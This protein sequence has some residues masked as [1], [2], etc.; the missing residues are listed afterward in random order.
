LYWGDPQVEADFDPRGFVDMRNVKTK[1]EFLEKINAIESSEKKWR[2]IV[3][4][5]ALTAAK[6]DEVREHLKSVGRKILGCVGASTS[7]VGQPAV[8]QQAPQV[9]S[10]SESKVQA[11]VQ[12]QIQK[13]SAE[14][15]IIYATAFNWKFMSS[16]E[17]WTRSLKERGVTRAI[18]YC[19]SDIL[20]SSFE[21]LKNIYTWITFIRI[22]QLDIPGFLDWNA[23]QHY[24]W[25][26][27]CLQ[28]IT[29]NNDLSGKT[30]IYTDSGAFVCKEPKEWIEKT[31]RSGVCLLEDE[32]QINRHW[33]H[34]TFCSKLNVT[35]QEKSQQQLMAGLIA[36]V[37]GHLVA[38]TL[39]TEAW[40]WGQQRDVIVGPKWQGVGPDGKPYGHRHDQSILSILS[41]RMGV[42]RLPLRSVYC[43]R[44]LRDTYRTGK[45][46]YVHRGNFKTSEQFAPLISEAHV[47]NL[48]RRADRMERFQKN[49]EG[50]AQNVRKFNAY[51]G[52]SITL[53]PALARLF[54]PHD[55][56]WKKAILG[57]ALSHL[58]LWLSLI[59]DTADIG[60][61]LIMEDDVKFKEGWQQRWNEAAAHA[62]DDWDVIYLGGILPPNRDGFERVKE[63]VNPYFSRVALNQVFGQQVPSRYFHFCNYSYI[64]SRKGAQKIIDTLKSKDGYWTS[65][66]HMICN[67]HEKMN[68]Y[69][70]DPL[71]AGCYQDD[72]PKYCASAF[73]NYSRVDSFDS[74]LW[75][76][77]ERF[78]QDEIMRCIQASQSAPIAFGTALE[79]ARRV[80]PTKKQEV[81]K[82]EAKSEAKEERFYIFNNY[83]GVDATYYEREWIKE[84]FGSDTYIQFKNWDAEKEGLP[85]NPYVLIYR[86]PDTVTTYTQAKKLNDE[87]KPFILLHLSDEHCSD[88]IDIYSLPMCKA[89]L[90]NYVRNDI[91]SSIQNKVKTIPLGPHFKLNGQITPATKKYVW[92]FHGTEWHGRSNTIAMLNQLQPNSFELYKTWQDANQLK[93]DE[94]CS[95]MREAIFVPCLRGNNVETYRFYEALELGAI[96]LIVEEQIGHPYY[97]MLRKHMPSLVI[98]G[99]WFD[100]FQFVKEMFSNP[101][102]IEQYHREIYTEWMAWKDEIKNFIKNL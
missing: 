13:E 31:R 29:L 54:R 75:N 12:S 37:A 2:E 3:R 36:F 27:W 45:S 48:E 40:K 74:D 28:D 6:A 91:P 43:D 49:H 46:I 99:S 62:P 69:F 18:A 53:T 93:Q 20:P 22:P 26:L 65:A 84:I 5:P 67:N 21:N 39:F 9:V 87:S 25:K 51:D 11:Q 80:D 15:G 101:T 63:K 77:D 95:K 19:M 1:E 57:C 35:E 90:R 47:I 58:E 7:A 83:G 44:S 17:L 4:T 72:D 64:L 8:V 41:A 32:E 70:L 68:L 59:T 79:D 86:K 38:N 23:P 96:P 66:D 61:Y 14:S 34:T 88:P 24:A 97:A 85:T 10:V 50:W 98:L 89:V 33:C 60:S 30:I 94:Y 82:K 73:N 71:V 55:F 52:R 102:K 100:S 56:G 42:T 92:S 78:S 16:F 81:V 76:N